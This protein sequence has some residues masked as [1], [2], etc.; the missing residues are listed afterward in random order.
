MDF[1]TF[2]AVAVA[3]VFLFVVAVV[4]AFVFV[5]V[6]FSRVLYAFSAVIPS[7]LLVGTVDTFAFFVFARYHTAP[8]IAV[9]ADV[10]VV[11]VFYAALHEYFV[12]L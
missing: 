3:V 7:V 2:V 1:V 9:A 6:I 10:V 8:S 12:A 11:F 4:V 5:A